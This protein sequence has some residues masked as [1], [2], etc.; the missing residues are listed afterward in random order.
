MEPHLYTQRELSALMT[1]RNTDFIDQLKVRV[2]RFYDNV[3]EWS[4][5]YST[6][7][8]VL[9]ALKDIASAN[10]S[11]GV[12]NWY[13][14]RSPQKLFTMKGEERI[15][16]RIH[17]VLEPPKVQEALPILF[18]RPRRELLDA[19]TVLNTGDCNHEEGLHLEG[20]ATLRYELGPDV[21]GRYIK[22]MWSGLERPNTINTIYL[23]RGRVS[24]KQ[25]T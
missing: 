20:L 24:N 5:R 19:L 18:N 10:T 23:H 3:E 2:A 12:W 16:V 15:V 25:N 9:G 6:A 14:P 7:V 11:D 22:L 13:I 17:Y 21:N 8:S 1:N 4:M